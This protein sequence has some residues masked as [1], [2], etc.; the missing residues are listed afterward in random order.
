MSEVYVG[1]NFEESNPN[2]MSIEERQHQLR[3]QEEKE[4]QR[5]E[6]EKKSPF[7]E[8]VQMN[9]AAYKAEDWLMANSPIA[10]RIFRFLINN[11][12]GFNAV[13]CSQ[14]VLQ[15]TFNVSRQTI[16]KAIKLLK[17][18][19]Y[20]NVYKSGTSN[21]YAINKNLVWN[22]Y[23]TNFKFAKFGANIIISESEQEKQKKI[24][25]VKHKEIIVKD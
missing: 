24:R 10:Y 12:D 1:N 18:N 16:S 23:G 15:E 21:V 17:D 25:A 6:R 4:K 20:I 7:N 19:K 22:S 9:K 3:E 13:V 5:I 11:M 2:I 14:A 8:F